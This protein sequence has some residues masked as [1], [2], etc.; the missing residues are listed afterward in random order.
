GHIQATGQDERGRKQYRYHPAFRDAQD[1]A[2]YDRCADFGEHLAKLRAR[3]AHD[4]RRRGLCKEKA[5]AAVVR[6]LD[7]G[8]IRVG[9]E[10]YA[11][12]NKSFG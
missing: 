1:A 8:S 2:K 10:Q 11:Q 4:L 9:N 5:V 6:L 3:V 12:A 7:L